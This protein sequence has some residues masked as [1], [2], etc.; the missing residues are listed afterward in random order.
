VSPII[1]N[2]MII[3][4]AT[5]S[6]LIEIILA[7]DL[8]DTATTP[9]A[10]LGPVT[11]PDGTTRT[12]FVRFAADA[13]LTDAA[14]NIVLITRKHRPGIGRLA[15]PGG[16]L[17][18]VDGRLEDA[19]TAARRELHEETGIDLALIAAARHTG[20][21]RR[22]YNRPFDLRT[23]WSDIQ[24]TEIREGDIFM[25]STQP[26]YLQT[27]ADLTTTPL[28]PADDATAAQVIAIHS[29]TPETLG[30][31]DQLEMIKELP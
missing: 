1:E 9:A 12:L 15:I 8:P 24:G 26:I 20:T 11:L 6:R 4:P 29:I 31:P 27:T 16:F 25:A 23:A 28:N 17:D 5:Q 30:I 3:D 10:K 13:V 7:A 22:R 19:L 18:L 2:N 14:R 21:G